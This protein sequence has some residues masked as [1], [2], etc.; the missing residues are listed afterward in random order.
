MTEAQCSLRDMFDASLLQ[1]TQ[2]TVERSAFWML[3]PFLLDKDLATVIHIFV[4]SS[5][6]ITTL[7]LQRIQSGVGHL[8]TPYPPQK[9]VYPFGRGNEIEK[10]LCG[11]ERGQELRE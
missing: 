8:K 7:T 10:R 9:P 2:I 6:Y 11:L 3:C 5:L 4:T 1:D